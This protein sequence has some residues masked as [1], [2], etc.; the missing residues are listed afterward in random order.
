[1]NKTIGWELLVQNRD[2]FSRETVLGEL[3]FNNSTWRYRANHSPK[4]SVSSS[5]QPFQYVKRSEGKTYRVVLVKVQTL[6]LYFIN[7]GSGMI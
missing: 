4:S 7:L 1:M 3:E 6:S 5:K 2:T